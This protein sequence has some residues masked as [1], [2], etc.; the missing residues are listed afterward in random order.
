[1]PGGGR[2]ALDADAGEALAELGLVLHPRRHL[3]ADVAAL[4]EVD[5]V[6]PLEAELENVAVVGHELDAGLG[7]RPRDPGR[8]ERVVGRSGGR[9]RGL[10]RDDGAPAER[11]VAGIGE[12]AVGRGACADDDGAVGR[13]DRHLRAQAVEAEALGER[14]GAVGLD[15][16]EDVG[17]VG[18]E[19]EVE[20]ILALRREQRG[21]D[22]A[23]VEPVHV[24]GD[25]PLEEV[26]GIGPGD[27]QHGAVCGA[28]AFG[29]RAVPVPR[30][31]RG[32]SLPM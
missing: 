12:G 11:G 22:R 1:M 19:E 9:R 20:E 31:G 6:Q 4:A 32:F 13:L 10:G 15:V 21:I 25:E 2:V 18:D 8:G 29:H 27:A 7:H 14:G 23:V 3:L 28:E 30:N 16:D 5:A 24:V 26:A 17:A